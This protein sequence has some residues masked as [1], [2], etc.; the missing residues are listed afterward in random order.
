MRGGRSFEERE[1]MGSNKT[2]R[3]GGTGGGP[4]SVRGNYEY[5]KA[6]HRTV[7]ESMHQ[8]IMYILYVL[9]PVRRGGSAREGGGGGRGGELVQKGF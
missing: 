9:Q 6:I 3:G 7:M 1:D 4:Q 5:I 8:F 2:E